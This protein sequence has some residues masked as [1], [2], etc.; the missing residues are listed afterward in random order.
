MMTNASF[1]DGLLTVPM[2]MIGIGI[3]NHAGGK[4][5]AITKAMLNAFAAFT[6]VGVDARSHIQ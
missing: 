6:N 1:A 2:N 5:Y 4:R 3:A